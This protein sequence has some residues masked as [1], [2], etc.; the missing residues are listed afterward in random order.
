MMISRWFHL[1]I[2]S[3]FLHYTFAIILLQSLYVLK[4]FVILL[5][6]F[7]FLK[8]EMSI[9]A[10][11]LFHYYGY[12]VRFIVRDGSAHRRNLGVQGGPNAPPIFFIP[13]NSFFFGY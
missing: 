8:T 9:M 4:F 3:P 5:N 2:L 10:V 13:K 6:T 11:L 12:D 7:A 1:P